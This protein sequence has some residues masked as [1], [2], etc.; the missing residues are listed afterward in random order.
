MSQKRRHSTWVRSYLRRRHQDS[1][2]YSLLPDLAELHREKFRQFFRMELRHLRNSFNQQLANLVD[3]RSAAGLSA[4]VV[5]QIPHVR[6]GP[7]VATCYEEVSDTP[8]HLDMTV[9]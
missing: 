5:R 1:V 2:Y 3:R 4:C 9:F 6:H 8:N 7:L